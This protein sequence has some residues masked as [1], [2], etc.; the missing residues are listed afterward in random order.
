[1]TERKKKF[2][3]EEITVIGEELKVGDI[4]P[5]FKAINNDL[6]E[7]NFYKEDLYRIPKEHLNIYENIEHTDDEIVAD[8]IAGMT[9]TFAIHVFRE[10]C[11]PKGWDTR[12]EN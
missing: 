7:Y 1:M 3:E 5:D 11:I 8:Y 2:G 6:S 9:D 4:A 12:D 10:I